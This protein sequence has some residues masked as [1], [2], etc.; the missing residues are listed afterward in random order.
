[1][2]DVPEAEQLVDTAAENIP[3]LERRN[4]AAENFLST[5][6]EKTTLAPSRGERS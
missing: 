3:D 2:L 6:L 4:R 1:M 5:L